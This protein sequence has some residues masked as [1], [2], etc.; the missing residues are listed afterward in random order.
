M[1]PRRMSIERILSPAPDGYQAPHM[2]ME[3]TREKASETGM[4]RSVQAMKECKNH[5]TSSRQ[6]SALLDSADKPTSSGPTI[7]A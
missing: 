4:A 3:D 6:S 7:D 2:G 5:E 1:K